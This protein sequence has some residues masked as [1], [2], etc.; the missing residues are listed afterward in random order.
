M[1]SRGWLLFCFPFIINYICKV[2]AVIYHLLLFNI[3]ERCK[4]YFTGTR[5]LMSVMHEPA[6]TLADPC[7]YIIRGSAT[8]AVKALKVS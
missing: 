1:N 7:L 6:Q 4:I 8:N 2:F 3:S 5:V